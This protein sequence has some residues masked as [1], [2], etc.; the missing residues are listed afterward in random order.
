[1]ENMATTV[2]EEKQYSPIRYALGAFLAFFGISSKTHNAS[3]KR[4]KLVGDIVTY[5]VLIAGGFLMAYPFWWMLAA[6]FADTS[7]AAFSGQI[8]TMIWWPSRSL[9]RDGYHFFYNY[10]F[11]FTRGMV[12]GSGT[13]F[14]A[15]TATGA[16]SSTTSFTPSCPSWSASSPPRP[17]L[18]PS[19]RST[20]RDATSCSCSCSQRSWSPALRS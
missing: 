18:L 6:S 9:P 12:G 15:V 8:N 14:R 10:E 13:R 17:Q 2:S 5:I 11:L 20:G 19:R 7:Q 4:A 1:M 16:P 3:K